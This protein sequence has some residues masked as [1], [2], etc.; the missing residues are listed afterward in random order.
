MRP[1]MG[2][3]SLKRRLVHPT[4]ESVHC[5]SVVQTNASH[6]RQVPVADEADSWQPGLIP[7]AR[8]FVGEEEIAAV[9]VVLE[10]GEL[11]QG[12]WVAQFEDAFA[13]FCGAN[14]AVATSSGTTALHLAL[15]AH[16]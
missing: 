11:T 10:S 8:P 5:P 15:L 16:G 9:R 12:R 7:I 3:S 13:A 14:Y 1:I 2:A 4:F 6:V